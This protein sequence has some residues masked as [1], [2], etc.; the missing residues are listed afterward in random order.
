[1]SHLNTLVVID[2]L[3]IMIKHNARQDYHINQKPEG[4]ETI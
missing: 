1:M 4:G 3:C 2:Y